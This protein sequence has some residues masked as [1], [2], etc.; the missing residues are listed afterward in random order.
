MKK[1]IIGYGLWLLLAACLYFFENN[2]GTRV[3][4]VC[5]LLFPLLPPLRRDFFTADET[6]GEG[7]IAF[8]TVRYFDRTEAEEPGE[9]RPYRPGDPVR[10]IHWKLT[11]R[12]GELLVR[13]TAAEPE[14]REETQRNHLSQDD[15]G[16]TRRGHLAGCLA[17]LMLLCLLL[18]LLIPE[19]R[20]GAMALFNRLFARSEAVNAYAYAY[21]PVPETQGVLLAS[22]LIGVMLPALAAV[23][24]F[25]RSRVLLLAVAAVCT[26]GQA[27]F[28]LSLPVWANLLL[29]G[30]LALGMLSRPVSAGALKRC[31]I[32]ALAVLLLVVLLLPGVDAA[33]EEASETVRDRL[34]RIAEQLTG[35]TAELP[36]GD[37]EVRHA[38]T[39]SLITGEGAAKTERTYRLVTVEEKQISIPHWVDYV[40]MILLLLLT[41]ALVLLPFF[42]F[43][44]LNARRKK[45]RESRIVFE[46]ENV[47]E[48]QCA[49][50]RQVI[51]WLDETGNGAGNLLFREWAGKLPEGLPEGY[52]ERFALCAEDFEEAA[53]SRHTLPE[54]KRER[55]LSLLRET[56]ETLWRKAGR[57]QRFR[58]KYWMCLRE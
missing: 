46:S 1:R 41:A 48:A 13:E 54:E 26:L 14:T 2:T 8:R 53:Y 45:A 10:R 44:L 28:G 4:L 31:G 42:P 5:S 19:A 40:K 37:T 39:Q 17:L 23:A 24:F 20:R 18:L 43:L 29:Y 11:A 56:E 7:R 16:K 38:H 49:I 36:E 52:A 15:Q 9:I 3:I 30:F 35:S 50:F 22:L 57:R 58:L 33:T 32:A 25:T 34:S 51:R 27:Y 6:G 47:S 12:K 55:A 21:F